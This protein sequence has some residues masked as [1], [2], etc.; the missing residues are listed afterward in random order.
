MKVD[1]S[2]LGVGSLFIATIGARGALE[3]EFSIANQPLATLPSHSKN[4]RDIKVLLVEDSVD[5]QILIQLILKKYEVQVD[6]ASNGL[7]GLE[8]AVSKNYDVILMDMQ[9]PELDGYTATERLRQKGYTKP[10]I[11]LT[12]HAMNEERQRTK[13]AGCDAHLTK[14][15]DFEMLIKTIAQFSNLANAISN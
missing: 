5:N 11:A 13:L 3:S 4:L 15:L 8:K 6:I 9:M 10:I 14:P 7:E 12:A 2:T 1:A